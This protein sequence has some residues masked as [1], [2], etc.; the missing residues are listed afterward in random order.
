VIIISALR[1][2]SF[3]MSSI[4]C[5][6]SCSFCQIVQWKHVSHMTY[7]GVMY[8]WAVGSIV[9]YIGREGSQVV[10]GGIMNVTAVIWHIVVWWMWGQSDGILWYTECESSHKVH[11]CKE[12]SKCTVI[13]SNR[14]PGDWYIWLLT[15]LEFFFNTSIFIKWAVKC[16]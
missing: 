6:I 9:W 14:C 11:R 15:F 3:C 13:V 10:Y 8:V 16:T 7:C 1:R 4:S 5:N 2:S 12:L